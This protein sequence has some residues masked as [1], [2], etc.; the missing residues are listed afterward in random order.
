V[1]Y[2]LEKLHHKKGLVECHMVK[3]LN[4]NPILQEK[5]KEKEKRKKNLPKFIQ[6]YNKP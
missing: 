5:K 2:Y 6:N 3:A 1:G 4:S